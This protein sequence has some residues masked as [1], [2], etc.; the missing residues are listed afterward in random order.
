MECITTPHLSRTSSHHGHHI[1]LVA[2]FH[3]KRHLVWHYSK[4]HHI[5]RHTIPHHLAHFISHQ[6]LGLA[7]ISNRNI[8]HIMHHTTDISHCTPFHITD[9]PHNATSV[10][11]HIIYWPHHLCTPLHLIFF[12]LNDT[13]PHFTCSPSCIIPPQLVTDH[14]QFHIPLPCFT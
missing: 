4:P 9:I 11:D 10:S 1:L 8:G 5:P 7:A 13:A 2:S 6:H 3:I 14:A 12:F